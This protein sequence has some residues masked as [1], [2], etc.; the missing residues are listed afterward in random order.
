MRTVEAIATSY[1]RQLKEARPRG[2][3]LLCGYSFGG[4]V[5]FEMAQQ[6]TAMGDSV[7]LLVM[8]DTYAPGIHQDAMR[9]DWRFYQPV[10]KPLKR[11]LIRTFLRLGK[12]V[13]AKLRTFYITDTYDHAVPM[14]HP[15]TYPGRITV[16]KAE[17]AWGPTDLGWRDLAGGGIDSEIVP[18]DHYT[19]IQEPQIEQLSRKLARALTAADTVRYFDGA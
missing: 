3:Y 4:I 17:R 16:F 5:A 2:P 7:P 13:P 12:L 19:M 15:R 1:V 8:M 9:L 10:L 6:L 18:G 11:F 14:Y